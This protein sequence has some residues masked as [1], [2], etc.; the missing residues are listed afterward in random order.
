MMP[1][2]KRLEMTVA[3][4]DVLLHA[5]R[6]RELEE[7]SGG[8]RL[9]AEHI[10]AAI[11]EY[12]ERLAVRPSYNVDD[13]SVVYVR[14]SSPAEWSVYLDLWRA[15]GGCSDLTAELRLK[16]TLAGLYAVEIDNIHVL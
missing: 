16:D 12:P 5:G 6:Y 8:K 9:R 7:L 11:E 3:H 13:L 4:I 10:A 1:D 14:D 2:T 15:E